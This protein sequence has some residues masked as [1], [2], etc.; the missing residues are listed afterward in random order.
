[1]KMRPL[2]LVGKITLLCI[3]GEQAGLA[4]NH[5]L[6]LPESNH[7]AIFGGTN[8]TAFLKYGQR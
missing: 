7:L 1:M 6:K 8:S 4:E 5:R 3:S 2:L